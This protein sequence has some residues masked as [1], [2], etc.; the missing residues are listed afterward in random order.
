MRVVFVVL[1]FMMVSFECRHKIKTTTILK[2]RHPKVLFTQL[3]VMDAF[4]RPFQTDTIS[5]LLYSVTLTAKKLDI[6]LV[7]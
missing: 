6:L 1:F 3:P 4:L 5:C 7:R 2:I